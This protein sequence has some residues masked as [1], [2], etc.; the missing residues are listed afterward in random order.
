MGSHIRDGS[1]IAANP[2]IHK[3]LC[4]SRMSIAKMRS[5]EFNPMLK[6]IFSERVISHPSDLNI[7]AKR[8]SHWL[9]ENSFSTMVTI[10]SRSTNSETSVMTSKTNVK[11]RM[12]M[13][14]VYTKRTMQTGGNH[15]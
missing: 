12:N 3:I 15:V 6:V 7:L 1:A 11:K 8:S 4:R 9:S 14:S 13:F 2:T 10:Q 5:P